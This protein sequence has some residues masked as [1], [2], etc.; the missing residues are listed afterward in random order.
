[1]NLEYFA[2]NTTHKCV[3]ENDVV[4]TISVT[5]GELWRPKVRENL[6]NG[7]RYSSRVFAN[8]IHIA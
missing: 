7:L 5:V 8:H 4:G 6:K 1:M 3:L 2:L